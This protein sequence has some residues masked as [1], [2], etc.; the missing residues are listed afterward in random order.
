M[1]SRDFLSQN[2]SVLIVVARAIDASAVALVGALAY[3]WTHETWVLPEYY[4]VAL[5]IAFFFTV[6]LFPAFDLYSSWRG[7][8]ALEHIRVILGAVITLMI[9]LV[10][11]SALSK[12]TAWFSRA[13][14][15]TWAVSSVVVIFALKRA[16]I[17]VLREL[18]GRGW[19]QRN[20][21]IFGAGRLGCMVAERLKEADWAGFQIVSFFDDE[22]EVAR[23]NLDEAGIP[24]EV[25]GPETDLDLYLRDND[26]RELWLALPLRAEDRVR[27]LLFSLRHSTVSIRFIPNL[28]SFKLF[29]GLSI[30]DVAGV[31]VVN[32]NSTPMSGM[33]RVLKEIE[34]RVLAFLIL[35]LVSPVMA[36]IALAIRLESRGP[37]LYKQERHG[38]DGRI[39]KVYKFRSMSVMDGAGH[40]KQATKGDARITK[41]GAF[42][43]RTSLDELPQFFNVLQG[44]MSIVGPRP[45]AL[46]HNEYYKD[47]VENYFQRHKVKP[48][49]TG[50]AQINGFRGETDTLEKMEKRVA[51]DLQYIQNW[52]VGLDLKI[53]ALTIFRVFADE[54]AY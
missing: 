33:N 18:R 15:G 52:S 26:I 24:A 49:I 23:K 38:W 51:Y 4:Q 32:V 46:S 47:K 35:G 45:H 48:G 43:R 27:D 39:I 31:P 6:V 37:I 41:V 12:T 30:T 10:I 19:N 11:M 3:F 8:P 25:K 2:E 54:K 53:I 14:F 17:V 29:L 28:F 7:R 20:I 44:R 21:V 13:W 34:D 22:P 1:R 36:L 42:I 5:V 16:L 40:V 9:C 50:L